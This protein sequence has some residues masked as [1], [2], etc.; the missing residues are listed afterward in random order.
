MKTLLNFLER[1]K[2]IDSRIDVSLLLL[3]ALSLSLQGPMPNFYR[4][5]HK[6]TSSTVLYRKS[7]WS[8]CMQDWKLFLLLQIKFP[9]TFFPPHFSK[10]TDVPY[11]Y[12]P[13]YEVFPHLIFSPRI[14]VV[15]HQVC[16][17]SAKY[18]HQYHCKVFFTA[19][20]AVYVFKSCCC[21]SCF[22][23]S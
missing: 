7:T 22:L 4:F 2:K 18:P 1:R 10:M 17:H 11:Q 6:C 9:H 21:S 20:I 15:R 5:A 13:V 12:Q 23:V 16:R 3:K 8:I 14:Y 19:S